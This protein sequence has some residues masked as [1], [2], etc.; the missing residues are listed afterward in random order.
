[1]SLSGD[2]DFFLV[3]VLY[4]DFRKLKDQK[5][6]PRPISQIVEAVGKRNARA[7]IGLERS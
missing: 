1:M 7:E 5:A 4:T 6:F 2:I 3:R